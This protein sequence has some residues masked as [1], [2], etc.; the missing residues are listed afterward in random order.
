MRPFNQNPRFLINLFTFALVAI[1]LTG[2]LGGGGEGGEG[3]ENPEAT[4]FPAARTVCT[5]QCRAQGQCGDNAAG[6][7]VILGMDIQPATRGQN[8]LFPQDA[9]VNKLGAQ[10]RVVR[11][12]QTNVEEIWQF[13]QVQMVEGG[14]TG[15]VAGMCLIDQ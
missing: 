12:P 15:W 8:Q 1:L 11:H 13:V 9:T 2:C 4:P 10:D 14:Q 5:E 3:G 7:P 6:Q